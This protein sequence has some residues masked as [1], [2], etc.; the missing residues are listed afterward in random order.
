MARPTHAGIHLTNHHIVGKTITSSTRD[1]SRLKMTAARIE[2]PFW[3]SSTDNLSWSA[4]NLIAVGGGESIAILVPRLDTKGPNNLPWDSITQRVSLFSTVEIPILNPSSS[5][6]WSVAEEL[7]LRHVAS[8]KWSSPGLGRFNT[9]A[10][11]ILHSNHT[12]AIWE[13]VGQPHIKDKWRRCL[14]VNHAIQAYYGSEITDDVER[15]QIRQRIRSFAW[16]PAVQTKCRSVDRMLDPHL[17]D[18]E[19]YLAL[20]TDAGD[21]FIL[22]VDSPYDILDPESLKWRVTVVQCLQL[23]SEGL[24]SREGFAL[25]GAPPTIGATDLAFSDWSNG[26]KAH[27]AY[28]A[29]GRLYIC[30]VLYEA[31]TDTGP[32]LVVSEPEERVL[33][34]S[35]QLSGPVN[36]AP[37]S[38]SLLLFGPDSIINVDVAKPGA[39]SLSHHLD[40]RWDEITGVAFTADN[41]ATQTVHVVSHMSTASSAT[42][43]L[44]M[45]LEASTDL[46]ESNWQDAIHESKANFSALYDLGPNVQE[47]TWGIASS[48]LGDFLATCINLLP[49]DSPAHI[50]QSEQRS[51]VAITA[52]LESKETPFPSDRGIMP[53]QDISAEAILYG[54]R[55]YISRGG[56]IDD[57]MQTKNSIRQTI[58]N[59]LELSLP[60]EVPPLPWSNRDDSEMTL[61]KLRA[62]LTHVKARLFWE[63]DMFFQRLDRLMDI[64]MQRKPKL[65]LTKDQYSHLAISVLDLPHVLREASSFSRQI[66]AAFEAIKARLETPASVID[67]AMTD[68]ASFVETCSI[69]QQSIVL[70]SLRWSRCA[71]GHQFSRCTLTF[72]SIMEPGI[73]KSCRICHAVY[74]NE[75]ALPEFKEN[76]TRNVKAA[77]LPVSGSTETS[78][79]PVEPHVSLARLL[80]SACN[81][82]ILCGGKFVA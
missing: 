23:P 47:R 36:F 54:A 39:Q 8:L 9:C 29:S 22:R 74:L 72:L 25:S 37:N 1:F 34:L 51:V 26:S 27:F 58:L 62:C 41:N 5:T 79:E 35:P 17:A 68:A 48:P 43:S 15:R 32:R 6:N 28:I 50:I 3:P 59:I 60:V 30:D 10:L 75:Y 20:S 64:V 38:D 76:V 7:S 65:Q 55:Q 70:E 63:E 71:G 67:P 21:I 82:C 77:P 13:C 2:V 52:N 45:S 80:F 40:G 61:D 18:R 81:V 11:A 49:S 19:H 12:M 57:S 14:L 4:D 69:C 78:A 46:N 16:A 56:K 73:S 66:G 42:S 44:P 33:P 31:S 53:S 24:R